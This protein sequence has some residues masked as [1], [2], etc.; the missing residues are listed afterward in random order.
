MG[1][2][3]YLPY[4][5]DIVSGKTVPHAF[6]WLIWALLTGIGFWAQV[7]GD[8]GPGAWSTGIT[9]ASCFTIFMFA[10]FRGER[11]IAPFDWACLIVGL[12][13]IPIWLIT[14]TPLWSVLL[15]TGVDLIAFLPTYR[16]TFLKPSEET[17]LTYNLSSL[18][19]I[20]GIMALRSFSVVTVLFPASIVLTN[21]TF[22]AL[23]YWR[24]QNR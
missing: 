19:F 13:G 22:V 16:K 20:L 18:K 11:N 3:A 14:D 10:L 1:V 8:G 9:S 21:S 6:S 23:V 2:I 24:R 5:R 15:I 17:L 7:T 4:L 12:A